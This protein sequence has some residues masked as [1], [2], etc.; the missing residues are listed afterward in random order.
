MRPGGC[1]YLVDVEMTAW[2][3]LGAEP[4]AV[5]LMDRYTTFHRARGNDPQIGLRLGALL[6]GAGL[7]LVEHRGTW[8]VMPAPVGV[9]PPPW[10]AREAMVRDGIA[11]TDDVDRWQAALE[12]MDRSTTRPTVFMP[13]F[14]ATARRPD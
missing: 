1:V 7:E 10:V 4:D 3:M 13:F 8:T 5:D 9:R 14:T 12:R 2:R 6:Q 11:T